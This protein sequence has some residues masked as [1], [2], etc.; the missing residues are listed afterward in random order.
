MQGDLSK[1]ALY[2]KEM[3][4]WAAWTC[5]QWKKTV[6]GKWHAASLVQCKAVLAVGTG[7][8]GPGMAGYGKLSAFISYNRWAEVEAWEWW[9]LLETDRA[10]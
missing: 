5:Q 10:L 6:E 8:Y 1:K 7:W 3:L 4:R 9:Q 2:G